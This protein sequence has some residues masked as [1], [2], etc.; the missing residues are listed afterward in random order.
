LEAS[1]FTNIEIF[2]KGE[3]VNNQKIINSFI[4]VPYWLGIAADA[5]WVA[6]LFSPVVF[7]TLTGTQNFDPD[8]QTRLIMVMGGSLMAGWTLLLLWAV[9]Q[10]VERRF[11]SLLTAFPVVFGMF[12]VALIGYLNGNTTNLWLILKTIVLLISMVTSF[13]LAKK[14]ERE[15]A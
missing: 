6:G 11:V 2:K 12:V 9:Q 1:D 3:K 10:P 14:I 7:A 13:L 8:L 5:L 4:K 15:N